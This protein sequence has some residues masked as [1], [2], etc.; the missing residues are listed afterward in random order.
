MKA[1]IISHHHHY[2]EGLRQLLEIAVPSL[3]VE[4]YSSVSQFSN[5]DSNLLIVEPLFYDTE[6]K[7]RNIEKIRDLAK[8]GVKV[9]FITDDL[10]DEQLI[11]L[12]SFPIFGLL[13]K[14]MQ[15]KE[16]ILAIKR[17]LKGAYYIPPRVGKILLDEYQQKSI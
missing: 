13:F 8:S 17:I 10:K 7:K 6:K 11:E 1:C 5:N 2:R 16:V 14:S 12:L 4:T 9:C 15:A 3:S